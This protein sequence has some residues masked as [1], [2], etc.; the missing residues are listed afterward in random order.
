MVNWIKQNNNLLLWILTAGLFSLF[1]YLLLYRLGIHPYI[2]WDEAIYAQVAKEMFLSHKL[3]NLTLYGADWF[4]KP[5]LAFWIISIFYKFGGVNELMGRLPTVIFALA[6]V[7][8]TL[9]WVYELRKSVLA[10]LLAMASFFLPFAFLTGAYFLNLDNMVGFFILVAA[11]SWY[12]AQTN[13]KWYL[14]FGVALGLGVM[15]KSIVALFI[16]VPIF[17]TYLIYR[18]FSIL[19]DKNFWY[20]VLLFLVVAAPWHIYMSIINGYAFWDKYFIYHILKRASSNLE[21]NGAPFDFFIRILFTQYLQA[22]IL[23][24]GSLVI[25]IWVFI[26]NRSVV[27]V[28]LCFVILFLIISSSVTKLAPYVIITIPFL[29][30]L[31]AVS[32]EKLISLIKWPWLK[33]LVPTTLVA[34]LI[35]SSYSFNLYKLAKG[36]TTMNYFYQ[37]SVGLFLKDNYLD[38]PVFILPAGAEPIAI[39]YYSNRKVIPWQDNVFSETA[40]TLVYTESRL[41]VYDYPDFVL[42]LWQ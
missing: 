18:Q 30:I 22:L 38:K 6:T 13:S 2:D 24:G 9:R 37:K 17:V 33:I 1:G 11:Y 41:S 42:L 10:V 23:F 8:V 15:T 5:P 4:E 35:F 16:L 39:G 7:A 29:I 32:L 27:F 25:S 34:V 40:G 28:W 3:F 12:R 21:S 19:K 36:E 26:K 31:T 20:G 14:A